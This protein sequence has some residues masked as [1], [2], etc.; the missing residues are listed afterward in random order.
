MPVNSIFEF[1]F[2]EDAREEG[3]RVAQAIGGDMPVKDGYLDHEVIQDVKDPGH[4]MVLT[5]W[6]D[7]DK[8]DAVLSEYYSHPNVAR[9]IE[10]LPEPPHGFVGV[11]TNK[12]A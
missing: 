4:L 12:P 3:L 9:A 8:C 5:R 1:K 10:L 2:A 6:S 11:I 7:Q